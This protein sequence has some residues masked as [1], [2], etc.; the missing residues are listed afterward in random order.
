M[1]SKYPIYPDDKSRLLAL[2]ASSEPN[3]LHRWDDYINE[4][5]NWIP[6][7]APKC[8]IGHLYVPFECSRLSLPKSVAA[9]VAKACGGD[10]TPHAWRRNECSFLLEP[11][12]YRKEI[13]S[14]RTWH[15]LPV[16]M[17]VLRSPNKL[18]PCLYASVYHRD[19]FQIQ[20]SLAD[21]TYY[22]YDNSISPQFVRSLG[23]S[24]D[25]DAVYFS[26]DTVEDSYYVFCGSKGI[27]VI[28]AGIDNDVNNFTAEVLGTP[29]TVD[30]L[31]P[32]LHPYPVQ[33]LLKLSTD[34][35]GASIFALSPQVFPKDLPSRGISWGVEDSETVFRPAFSDPIER[36]TPP[37]R[38]NT[39]GAYLLRNFL[40]AGAAT[41]FEALKNDALAK[42]AAARDVIY[43][44]ISKFRDAFDERYGK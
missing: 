39:I 25:R 28:G 23:E 8:V 11:S 19:E 33:Q 12:S 17:V 13:G 32:W 9:E 41:I 1:V 42:A 35:I 6:W 16:W 44:E 34:S 14:V 29:W 43:E 10:I 15:R 40:D 3:D 31:P 37:V 21:G 24:I 20:K 2:D 5:Q 7:W 26:G 4:L 22:S 27:E 30:E 38:Q 18:V 36:H